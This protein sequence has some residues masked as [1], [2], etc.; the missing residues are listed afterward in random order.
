MNETNDVTPEFQELYDKIDKQTKDLAITIL[1]HV[2]KN[3][4]RLLKK[5]SN[6]LEVV[7]N[8]IS[9]LK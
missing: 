6:R 1:N 5:I 3:E 4:A 8:E 9:E 7:I 2:S